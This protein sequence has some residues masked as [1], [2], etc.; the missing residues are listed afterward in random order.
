[1]T[2]V[3]ASLAAQV[4]SENEMA[5]IHKQGQGVLVRRTGFW[6][7]ALLVVWGGQSLYTWLINT[8]DFAKVLVLE[9]DA[10]HHLDGWEIPVLQQRFNGGFLVAWGVVGLSLWAIHRL[11]NK[12]RS[13]DFLIETNEELKKVTWPSWADAKSSS[14]IV[15]GFVVFLALFLWSSDMFFGW[16]F[17]LLLA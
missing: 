3:T 12:K 14:T 8:F 13:A 4:F 11:L 2:F 17:R 15:L 7:L 10:A 9:R 1:M 6:A 5:E 16:I